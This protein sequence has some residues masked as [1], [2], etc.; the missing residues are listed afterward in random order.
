MSDVRPPLFTPGT[1][2]GTHFVVREVVCLA[3]GRVIYRADDN[4]ADRGSVLLSARWGPGTSGGAEVFFDRRLQ[5]PGIASPVLTWREHHQLMSVVPSTDG[6]PL[7]D[8][9]SPVPRDS[10]LDIAQRVLGSVAYLRRKGLR[11]KRLDA[12][13]LLSEHGSIRL[14]DLEV[15]PATTDLDTSDRPLTELTWTAELLR[16]YC[17]L[18]YADLLGML[19]SIERGVVRDPQ[20]VGRAVEREI[21]Q[22]PTSDGGPALAAA[23]T[24]LGL[25]R[26]LNE[27]NWGWIRL[28]ETASLYAVA[29]GM[30]GHDGGE[31]ASALAVRTICE[32]SKSKILDLLNIPFTA[33]D[34]GVA[35]AEALLEAA[36]QSANNTIKDEADERGTDMGT[37]MVTALVL[38]DR[39][40]LV[41]NVGDSRAYLLRRG[42]LHQI[43]RDHSLVANMVERGRLTRAEARVH[44]HSNILVRTVGGEHDVE[45]D[46]FRVSLEPADRLLLCTDGLWGEVEDPLIEAILA[47][48]ADTREAVRQ[49]VR[50]AQRSGGK[51][52]ITALI[53]AIPE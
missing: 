13:N 2:L 27:D 17:A 16:R 19:E 25:L 12:A 36:F 28:S 40:A 44:P 41:A 49:L 7:L 6:R 34:T 30:G 21:R 39:L 50:A 46:I 35:A 26:T 3:E 31:V 45:I 9:V 47:K 4:R 53:V 14:F 18:E 38:H 33:D 24:D 5:H 10:L 48:Q 32:V 42:V 22:T 51:D 15:V 37:T 1:S 11:L 8:E 20:A 52:N 23:W 29:D 43:S